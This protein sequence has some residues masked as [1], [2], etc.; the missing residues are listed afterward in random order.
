MNKPSTCLDVKCNGNGD[1]CGCCINRSI[2]ANKGY[3][4]VQA[5]EA[6]SASEAQT[7]AVILA[8]EFIK[9]AEKEIA[10]QKVTE[11]IKI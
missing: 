4:L 8:S 7:N 6:C 3:L 10:T 1:L 2:I 5:I 11:V 9:L